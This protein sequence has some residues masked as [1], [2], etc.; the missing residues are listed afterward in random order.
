MT[1]RPN[2]RPLPRWFYER[3]AADLAPD[4]VGRV[5]VREVDGVRLVGR[6]VEAEA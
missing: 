1:R 5:L 6:I 2:L 3:D 4:L